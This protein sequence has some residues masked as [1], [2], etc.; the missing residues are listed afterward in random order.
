MNLRTCVFRIAVISVAL[1]RQLAAET[2]G[3]G[4]AETSSY[5][6]KPNDMIRLAVFNEPAL[7]SQ[8]K[9]LQTGEAMFPLIGPVKIA[10]LSISASIEKIR[11][12]YDADYVVEPKVTLTVDDYALQQVSILGAVKS[13]GQVP[14]PTSGKLDL[15]AALASAGGLSESADPAAI[16]LE[17]ADGQKSMFSLAAVQRSTK[18]QLNPGD[19]IIVAESRYINTSVT[20][21]GQVRSSGSIPFPMDG[22][23][24][25]VTAVARAGGFTD[26][27]NPKKVSIN[28]KGVIIVVDVK[29]MSSKG[30]KMFRLEPDDILTVPERLF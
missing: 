3:V 5:V 16:A 23:L 26:L 19:R 25:I 27:A 4:E 14:I 20:F 12:L 13:P 24:D 15:S 9:V 30:A 17:R 6:I 22:E 18:I 21:V 8:T 28:R 1:T 11:A 2:S 7:S 29:D 10:G